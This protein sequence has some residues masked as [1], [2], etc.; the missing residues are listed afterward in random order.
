MS[1]P[2]ARSLLLGLFVLA[3]AA[4]LGGAVWTL[5]QPT[6]PVEPTPGGSG[7]LPYV[8][9]PA[10]ETPVKYSPEELS[11]DGGPKP[12]VIACFLTRRGP[13]PFQSLKRYDKVTLPA[14]MMPGF[15]EV[16][17]YLNANGSRLTPIVYRVDQITESIVT[18][19][20]ETTHS[21]VSSKA[22]LNPM[23]MRTVAYDIT[24]TSGGVPQ[25][26][27]GHLH[28]RGVTV[29]IYRGGK[30]V[31]RNEIGL[32]AKMSILPVEIEFVHL[33]YKEKLAEGEARRDEAVRW[34]FF[35]PE[36][37]GYVL[38]E[39][40][41]RGVEEI[42]HQGKTHQCA[43]Y[44]V[45]VT[46]T[47]ARE[48]VFS[49]QRMWFDINDD[50]MLRRMDFEAGVGPEDAL[51]TERVSEAELDALHPLEILA[52]KLPERSFPY[53]MDQEYRWSVRARNKQLG[54]IQAKFRRQGAD[55]LGPAG[56]TAEASVQIDTGGSLR[57]ET[58]LTR[59]DERHLPV[60][61]KAQGVES[62]EQRAE[63]L[64]EALFDRGQVQ[65]R[66]F[67]RLFPATPGSSAAHPE[68]PAAEHGPEFERPNDAWGWLRPVPV[69]SAEEERLD[70]ERERVQDQR[71]N[72]PL[73]PGT[74]VF[75]HH[76]I[77]QLAALACKLPL[78]PVPEGDRPGEIVYQKVG[79]YTVHRH[80][81]GIVQFAIQAE[82][83]PLKD[84]EHP[85][86]DEA[87]GPRLFLAHSVNTL[88][89]CSMLLAPDGRL[90]QLVSRYGTGE[91]IYTLDD[92]IMHARDAAARKLRGQEGPQLIRPPWF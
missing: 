73:D 22:Y 25:R 17:D 2:S 65:T 42:S 51:V 64:V 26:L 72:R 21:V 12:S 78:P 85:E 31:D 13:T 39:V 23:D 44:D 60:F 24:I 58:S 45:R 84:P 91:V 48:G 34:S 15:A 59:F 41:P 83:P 18:N 81:A 50:A 63:Y 70:Q 54:R 56:L 47:K 1:L 43:R 71:V 8:K 55:E 53:H 4:L 30:L 20:G 28:K 33:W 89:P 16:A 69:T 62:V 66:L 27:V 88:L 74:F 40:A 7:D 37:S 87:P 35:V 67:R 76:R 6:D 11:R 86:E 80:Q 90:L 82:P 68:R 14:T 61:Y 75:D 36:V 52:P 57:N 19:L 32:P 79:L 77:E 49:L 3:V 9:P 5:V 46:S 92:P 29:E 38:L 10:P